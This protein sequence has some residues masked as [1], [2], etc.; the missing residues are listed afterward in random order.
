M[1]YTCAKKTTACLY[2]EFS[3]SS[4]FSN[5]SSF[6]SREFKK[7]FK[8]A[9]FSS[10]AFSSAELKSPSNSRCSSSW[11][12]YAVSPFGVSRSTS[13]DRLRGIGILDDHA[14]AFK[15]LNDL[16]NR[17]FRH[18]QHIREACHMDALVLPDRFD[19]VNF[20]IKKRLICSIFPGFAIYSSESLVTT[21]K[22]V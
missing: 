13:L 18:A 16:G 10:E 6:S 22:K 5:A 7:S 8:N 15:L 3:A 14:L 1:L 2:S 21:R 17:A 20:G 9:L 12:R 11:C 4:V 19:H